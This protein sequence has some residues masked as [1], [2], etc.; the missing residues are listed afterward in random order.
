MEGPP[1]GGARG[2]KV[3]QATVD[4][5]LRR[6][7]SDVSTP[8][9][10]ERLFEALSWEG[11]WST[12][13]CRDKSLAPA[14][15]AAGRLTLRIEV[16]HRPC[17]GPTGSDSHVQ[18]VRGIVAL[19]ARAPEPHSRIALCYNFDTGGY[20][21]VSQQASVDAYMRTLNGKA[22]DRGIATLNKVEQIAGEPQ[23]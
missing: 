23:L 14:K 7:A 16:L 3:F 20:R 18:W 12:L 8:W 13:R 10:K 11:A 9:L 5:G 21:F 19:L 2:A 6:H 17:A 1:R 22:Y 4:E 15:D